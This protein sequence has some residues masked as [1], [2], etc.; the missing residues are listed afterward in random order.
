MTK[1]TLHFG[2]RVTDLDRAVAFYV[3]LGYEVL[4]T[5][6]ET[7]FGSLTMIKLPDDD[8]VTIELVHNPDDPPAA[9]GS[10]LNHVVI[11][12]PDM[13]ATLAS[14]AEAGITADG[15]TSPDGS[16]DFLTTWIADPDGHRI[17]LVQW[18]P[19]HADGITIADMQG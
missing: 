18:P 8:F 4:G 5:V 11:Q 3:A 16:A 2:L 17:E 19:G 15:P 10:D 13:A 1:R 14:L 6:P 7:A 9:I 12:V